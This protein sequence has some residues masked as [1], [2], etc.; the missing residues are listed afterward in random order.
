MKN[1]AETMRKTVKVALIFS[2][3]C[4]VGSGG[5]K[6]QI[7]VFSYIHGLQK[8][9]EKFTYVYEEVRK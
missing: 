9:G 4:H 5:S 1:D 8:V 6:P 3:K 2:R 7:V